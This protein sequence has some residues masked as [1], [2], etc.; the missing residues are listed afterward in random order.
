MPFETKAELLQHECRS[1]V[2]RCDSGLDAVQVQV[3]EAIIDDS[4]Q[5]LTR[6][7]LAPVFASEDIADL[8]ASMRLAP[9]DVSAFTDQPFVFAQR[10]RPVNA[11]AITRR[12]G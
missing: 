9:F 2:T 11:D 7:A 12:L 6:D 5:R 4:A 8:R 1:L 10:D 3:I